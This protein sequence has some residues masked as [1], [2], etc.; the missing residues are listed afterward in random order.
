MKT[1]GEDE[2]LAQIVETA[3][4]NNVKYAHLNTN[5][6]STL[7]TVCESGDIKQSTVNIF[8]D[9]SK[10]ET[11]FGSGIAIF[12]GEKIINS[13]VEIQTLQQMHEQS[14]RTTSNSESLR[15]NRRR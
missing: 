8:T 1:K 13:T 3:Y 11:G 14:S 5:I 15:C 4:K 6:T 12:V 9:G 2:F 7:V 10:N